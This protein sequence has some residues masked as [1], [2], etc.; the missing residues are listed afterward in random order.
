MP[1]KILIIN[2][3]IIFLY[4]IYFKYLNTKKIIL[5]IF[6][7][8]LPWI[9]TYQIAD[10][11]YKEKKICFAKEALDYDF[12]VSIQK[13]K[14]VDYLFNEIDMT[15]CYSQLMGI[16]SDNFEKGKPLKLSK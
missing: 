15:T 7:N 13:G 10:I 8:F 4:I 5:L 1:T 2:P 9:V 14:F 11:T 12:N 3:F 16:Y 6:F